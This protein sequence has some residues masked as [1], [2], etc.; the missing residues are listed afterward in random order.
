[1]P[2][3]PVATGRQGVFLHFHVVMPHDDVTGLGEDV[4]DA[5]RDE[6]WEN[7]QIGQALVADEWR[8]TLGRVAAQPAAPGEPPRKV[9][10]DLQKSVQTGR[11]GWANKA[12]TVMRGAI[13]ARH[14]G[15]GALEYGAPRLGIEPHPH[16]RPTIARIEREL[17]GVLTQGDAHWGKR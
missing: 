1:M 9:S 12:Q 13:E 4:L 5:L 8:R 10:G 11:K 2:A 17:E 3:L 16:Y 14:P 6:A 7:I 15:A